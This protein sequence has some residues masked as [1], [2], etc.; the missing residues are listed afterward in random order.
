[1]AWWAA[2]G[3][4]LV[5]SAPPSTSI[6]VSTAASTPPSGDAFGCTATVFDPGDRLDDGA[7]ER[8]AALT[9]SSL[10]ADVHVRAEDALDTGLD[11]RMAQLEARCPTWTSGAERSP[12]LVVVMF[13]VQRREASVFYGAEQGAMLEDRWSPAVDGMGA[14]F[15]QGDYT[16]GILDAL[17]GLRQPS[18]APVDAFSDST[19]RSSGPP[20]AIWVL[21]VLV[22]VVGVGSAVVRY[23]RT[24]EWNSSDD[25]DNDTNN[26]WSWRRRSFSSF[27]S[28]ARSSSR[29]SSRPRGRAGGGTKKW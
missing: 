19:N 12:D 17:R 18:T 28:G 24:G 1:M 25:D 14:E 15:R 4:A 13:S 6:P 5:A 22:A 29:S 27:R 9:A 16:G 2:L 21:V 26:G 20:G 8:E 3:L 11:A 7:V 10:G 23:L